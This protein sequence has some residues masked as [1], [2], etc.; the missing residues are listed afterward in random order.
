[1]PR[2]IAEERKP[3]LRRCKV[4][5]NTYTVMRRLTTGIHSEKCVVRQFRPCA[6]ITECTYISLDSLA[7][8]TTRLYGIAYC[9]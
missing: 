6:N 2:H 5:K 3:Q 4:S 1:M 7:Y 9:F 8:Y